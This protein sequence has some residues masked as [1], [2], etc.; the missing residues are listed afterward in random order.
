MKPEDSTQQE[1]VELSDS[2]TAARTSNLRETNP[3]LYG[4][5]AK[6]VELVVDDKDA[7]AVAAK[8]AEDVAS[9]AAQKVADDDDGGDNQMIPRARLNE[10]TRD[11]KSAQEEATALRARLEALE[12]AEAAREAAAQAAASPARDIE[13]ELNALEDQFDNG[14]I[15]ADEFRPKRRALERDLRQQVSDAAVAKALEEVERRNGEQARQSKEQEWTTASTKFMSDP[16]NAAY[17]DPIRAGA[18]NQAMQLVSTEHGG[19]I[20]Y[21]DL[22]EE[23]RQRVEKAFGGDATARGET[24]QDRVKRE[25]TAA[26]A[27]AAAQAS[28]LPDRPLGG[29]GQR[30]A[31][32]GAADSEA[33]SREEWKKLPQA[34]KDK[35]LGKTAAA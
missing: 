11:K 3:E 33:V 17:Q 31:G 7:E 21:A 8:A 25:R 22:L 4:G 35:M 10:V 13:A 12:Q 1:E 19:A 26:A 9:V 27:L 6:K 18:L 20:S 16:L 28:A 2:V 29:I 34:E 15:E 32:E 30:G 23:A 14:D 24:A 5:E